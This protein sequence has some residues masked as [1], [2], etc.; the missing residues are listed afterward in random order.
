MNYCQNIEILETILLCTKHSLK[1]K[2]YANVNI[3]VQCTQFPNL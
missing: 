2:Y 3:N 1:K